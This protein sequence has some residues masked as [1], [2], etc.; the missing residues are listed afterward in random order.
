MTLKYTVQAIEKSVY[1]LVR[2]KSPQVDLICK[3]LREAHIGVA[4][5]VQGRVRASDGESYDWLIRLFWRVKELGHVQ[6]VLDDH[7]CC[8]DNCKDG[9]TPEIASSAFKAGAQSSSAVN[10][11]QANSS[12][13]PSVQAL[14]GIL[15][16]VVNGTE[17]DASALFTDLKTRGASV[18]RWGRSFRRAPDG[19]MYDW[20]ISLNEP[21]NRIAT[22]EAMFE[23]RGKEDKSPAPLTKKQNKTSE[24]ITSPTRARKLGS[25][26]I[27]INAVGELERERAKT[28]GLEQQIVRLKLSHEKELKRLTEQIVELNWQKNRPIEAAEKPLP[29][30]EQKNRVR[31][32]ETEI[33]WVTQKRDEVQ[34]ELSEIRSQLALKDEEIQMFASDNAD[35]AKQLKQ[36]LEAKDEA[37]SRAAK[38]KKRNSQAGP[39]RP[40]P[41]RP[42]IESIFHRLRFTEDFQDVEQQYPDPSD[43]WDLLTEIQVRLAEKTTP[44]E[45]DKHILNHKHESLWNLSGVKFYECRHVHTGADDHGRVY[46]WRIGKSEP[47]LYRIHI[48]RKEEQAR[49]EARIRNWVLRDSV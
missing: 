41:D 8:E 2:G 26:A 40:Q 3:R 24:R 38:I 25:A 20:F 37:D 39:V 14:N 30:L 15:Y 5:C 28:K 23:A 35:L 29:Q 32:L 6:R 27:G 9:D 43:L 45:V 36:A 7:F 13:V 16:V 48:S 10:T 31:E 33:S 17:T 21:E 11:T 34:A 18:R 1:V 42:V 47:R 4:N 12:Q 22:I 49:E 46:F 44:I 19:K